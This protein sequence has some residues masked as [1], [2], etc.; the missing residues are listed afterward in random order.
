MAIEFYY[1]IQSLFNEI[2]EES[3]YSVSVDN[4]KTFGKHSISETENGVF[5]L[6]KLKDTAN[7]L[8]NLVHKVGDETTYE[9][10]VEHETEEGQF[11]VVTIDFPTTFNESMMNPIDSSIRNYLVHETLRKW[12]ESKSIPNNLAAQNAE[13]YKTEILSRINYQKQQ[14]EKNPQRCLFIL[15]LTSCSIK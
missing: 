15:N 4:D 6:R 10:D 2:V 12:Y 8:F 11:I 14:Q 1:N 9:Y 7:D 3:L 5:A 13:K